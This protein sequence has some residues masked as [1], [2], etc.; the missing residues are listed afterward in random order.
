MIFIVD[1]NR[2]LNQ[3]LKLFDLNRANPDTNCLRLFFILAKVSTILLKY[4]FSENS[5][6]IFSTHKPDNRIS[7]I[8]ERA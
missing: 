1:L 5:F 2:D 4:N 7:S 3:L 8:V 6:S